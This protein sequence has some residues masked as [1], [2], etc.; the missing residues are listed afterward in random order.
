MNSIVTEQSL[1]DPQV[2]ADLDAVMKR[3]SD[4]TPVDAPTSR[5]IED[6]A[7]CITEELRRTHGEIDIDQLLRSVREEA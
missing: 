7:E 5:R 6:R 2:I 4:G 3:I 1:S